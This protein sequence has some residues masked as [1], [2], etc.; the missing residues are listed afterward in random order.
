MY[1][2]IPTSQPEP[3]LERA[4]GLALCPPCPPVK[5]VAR[6]APISRADGT[7]AEE[8]AAEGRANGTNTRGTTHLAFIGP[9]SQ[10]PDGTWRW[11]PPEGGCAL[12]Y[13]G[14]P[15]SMYRSRSTV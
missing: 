14:A 1:R 11:E 3:A 12:H 13:G 7:L 8:W 6:S 10:D 5:Q 9:T 15:V 4:D 2:P